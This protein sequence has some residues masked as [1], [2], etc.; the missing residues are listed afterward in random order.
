MLAGMWREGQNNPFPVPRVDGM[1]QG[2]IGLNCSRK[3]SRC[4]AEGEV[5]EAVEEAASPSHVQDGG[6]DIIPSA[7][8]CRGLPDS[9]SP[10]Q[11]M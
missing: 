7:A 10:S 6:T 2:A 4:L 11:S 8:P 3:A 9:T 5:P 1:A